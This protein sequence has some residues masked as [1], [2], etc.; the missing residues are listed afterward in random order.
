MKAMICGAL[1]ALTVT[2]ANAA[3]DEQSADFM[4]AYCRLTA[5]EMTADIKKA[6]NYSRCVGIVEGVSQMFNLLKAAQ[7][8]GTVQLDPLL[9]T[10]IPAGI[11]K[12]QLVNVVVA[13]GETFPELTHRPFTV[14]A[15][16]A[17]H[18]AWPCK[19]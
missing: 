18:V 17:M 3:D 14:L 11:T 6:S 7:A 19:K 8:A 5:K 9:C 4:L 10:S 16:S 15:I 2:T 12:E 1:I 13:Y